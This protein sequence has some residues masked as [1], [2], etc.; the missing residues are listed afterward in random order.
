MLTALV[1][2]APIALT[3]AADPDDDQVLACA[4]A[5]HASCIV[6]GDKHLHSLGGWYQGIKIMR[7]S[8]AIGILELF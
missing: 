8:E 5:G 6:S 3:I 4:L 7:P 1:M 2:L